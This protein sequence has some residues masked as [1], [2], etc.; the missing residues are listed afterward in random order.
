MSTKNIDQLS[1]I[2]FFPEIT[3]ENNIKILDIWNSF[4]VK[5]LPDIYTS[6]AYVEYTPKT[7]DTLHMLAHKFYGN[8]KMWWVI[9]LINDVEDPFDFIKNVVDKSG[10]IKVLKSSYIMSILFNVA[11]MKN[12]KD[13]K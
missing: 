4:R 8:S 13:N 11:R 5:V 6:D 10:T 1:F 7:S 3:D 12:A 2:N 9:P